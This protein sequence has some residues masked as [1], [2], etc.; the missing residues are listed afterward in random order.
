VVGSK[1]PSLQS[2]GTPVVIGQKSKGAV[3][4]LGI[5]FS[6]TC[7]YLLLGKSLG[8]KEPLTRFGIDC[9]QAVLEPK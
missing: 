9:D 2:R 5:I 8:C 1:F 3:S 7:G 6:A 4:K